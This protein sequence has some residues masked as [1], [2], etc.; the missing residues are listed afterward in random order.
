MHERV[1]VNEIHAAFWNAETDSVRVIG[2]FVGWQER[3]SVKRRDDAIAESVMS[4]I[5]IGEAGRLQE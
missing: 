2:L 3:E 1:A 4:R 5:T